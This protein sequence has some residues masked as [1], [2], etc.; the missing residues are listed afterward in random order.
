MRPLL[1][2]ATAL[3]LAVPAAAAAN[4]VPATT[5]AGPSDKLTGTISFDVA[6]DGT[7]AVG[8]L[9]DGHAT[10]ARYANGAWSPA[11]R[12]DTG[13]AGASSSVSVTVSPGGRVVAAFLNGQRALSRV[14]PASGQPFTAADIQLDPAHNAVEVDAAEDGTTYA[15]TSTTGGQSD[16]RAYRLNGTTWQSVGPAFPDPAGALDADQ[17]KDA[18][19][20]GQE[21]PVLTAL[22][23]GGAVVAWGED[24]GV[25]AFRMWARRIDGLTAGPA[26]KASPDALDGAPSAKFALLPDLDADAAGRAW[27]AFRDDFVYGATNRARIL[28]RSVDPGGLGDPAVVDGLGASPTEGS[29]FPRVDVNAKGDGLL[30]TPRQLSNQSWA[31]TLTGGAWSPGFRMDVTGSDSVTGAWSALGDDGTGAVAWVRDP[32]GG[33]ARQA[34]ARRR[35]AGGAFGPEL[36]L[37]DTAL[38]SVE[39]QS[40]RAG[41]MTDC[42]VLVAFTQLAGAERRVA[43]ARLD[44]RRRRRHDA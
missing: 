16:V 34:L 11:E 6:P 20:A 12:V 17:A 13:L 38:G 43:V 8:F 18:G 33:G 9:L 28:V 31:A 4:V 44:A 26:R 3:L 22:R 1:A 41:A 23:G 35:P 21:G 37:A 42:S 5:V 30:A 39:G 7:A 14:S 29:E 40:V 24:E 15:V 32:G 36:P 25:S 27:L 19:P 10:V 2:L